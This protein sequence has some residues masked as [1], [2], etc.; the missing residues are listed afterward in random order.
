MQLVE[1]WV[2]NFVVYYFTVIECVKRTMHGIDIIIPKCRKKKL[3]TKLIQ[4]LAIIE[5]PWNGKYNNILVYD[6]H[7]FGSHDFR[8]KSCLSQQGIDLEGYLEQSNFQQTDL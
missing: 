2:W 7:M 4:I 6:R 8:L 5:G 1:Y 3:R